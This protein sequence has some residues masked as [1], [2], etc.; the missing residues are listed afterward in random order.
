MVDCS[1]PVDGRWLEAFAH[2]SMVDFCPF[3]RRWR[4]G[5]SG[6][7]R[8]EPPGKPSFLG[9]SSFGIS[10]SSDSFAYEEDVQSQI[11]AIVV[12]VKYL[13]F[14]GRDYVAK[15]PV[16]HRKIWHHF[17]LTLRQRPIFCWLSLSL[18]LF[19]HP[20]LWCTWGVW[21][22]VLWVVFVI[23]RWGFE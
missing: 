2:Q 19:Y 23:P 12:R 17:L 5:R 13:S 4:T 8:D 14:F 1:I 10:R 18:R 7:W 6:N 3:R 21:L 9:G 15:R 11:S 20:L 16:T 22:D